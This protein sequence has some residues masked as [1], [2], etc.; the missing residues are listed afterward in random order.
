METTTIHYGGLV[1]EAAI[2]PVCHSRLYPMMGLD[3]HVA[4]HERRMREFYNWKV[5]RLLRKQLKSS[6]L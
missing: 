2:C 1:F 3:R 6:R 5:L 4:E